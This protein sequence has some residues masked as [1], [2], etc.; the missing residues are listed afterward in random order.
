MNLK[1]YDD[2]FSPLP[3]K[4]SADLQSN[5][6]LIAF[7]S[8][9]HTLIGINLGVMIVFAL[10]EHSESGPDKK[11]RCFTGLWRVQSF[12]QFQHVNQDVKPIVQSVLSGTK[13]M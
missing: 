13:R 11:G 1:F 4:M 10:P 12:S 7:A 5:E 9:K 6:M 3:T 2:T 8:N